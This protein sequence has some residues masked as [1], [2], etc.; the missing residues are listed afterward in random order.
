MT[1]TVIGPRDERSG[2]ASA[3]GAVRR[4]STGMLRITVIAARVEVDVSV[5][6]GVAVAAVV[7]SLCTLVDEHTVEDRSSPSP[8]ILTTLI[9]VPLDERSTLVE[10]GV[11]D[12]DTLVLDTP[13]ASSAPVFDDVTDAVAAVGGTPRWSTTDSAAAA[14]VTVAGGLLVAGWAFVQASGTAATVVAVAVAI[15]A[16]AVACLALVAPAPPPVGFGARIG[17][18]VVSFA[19][20]VTTVPGDEPSAGAVLGFAAVAAT[21]VV[22]SMVAADAGRA[23]FTAVSTAALVGCMS[24]AFVSLTSLSAVT[25]A[26]V[27]SGVAVLA[28]AWAPRLSAARAGIRLPPVPLADAAPRLDRPDRRGPPTAPSAA[29]RAAAHRSAT[30]DIAVVAARARSAQQYLTGYTVGLSV[31]AASGAVVVAS[32]GI[33]SDQGG[34]RLVFGAVVAVVL[35]ARGR[36][37]RD[38]IRAACTI[39]AGVAVVLTTVAVGTST[40]PDLWAWWVAVGVTVPVIAT[41]VGVVAPGRRFSPV[42]RRCAELT[43]L[44]AVVAVVPL[45]CWVVG[46]FSAV[47]GL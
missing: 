36:A 28:L 40:R 32:S 17:A 41:A 35:C 19:A 45:V 15:V 10:N 33:D 22:T 4:V 1:S 8:R 20:G 23:S 12:G 2:H 6:A 37:Q 46:A 9:G 29:A 26:A 21:A 13:G 18:C 47:R 44:T 5:P 7:P 24:C 25:V 42:A 16:T 11:S 39:G 38:R 30:T 31:A 34:V 3:D 27:T 43:E 14:A